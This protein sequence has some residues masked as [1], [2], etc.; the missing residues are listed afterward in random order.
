MLRGN[1]IGLAMIVVSALAVVI[2]KYMLKLDD[3][4]TMIMVGGYADRL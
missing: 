1:L 3:A 4:T 2:G